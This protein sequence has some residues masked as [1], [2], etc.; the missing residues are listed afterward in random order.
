RQ[1]GHGL[2]VDRLSL[3]P[4][5]LVGGQTDEDG[6]DAFLEG[7]A[8][9]EGIRQRVAAEEHPA[10]LGVGAAVAAAFGGRGN[11][12]ARLG[13]GVEA[14]DV[15]EVSGISAVVGDGAGVGFFLVADGPAGAVV[16]VEFEASL[17]AFHG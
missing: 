17:G 3:T 5:T 10:E 15:P 2:H 6:L 8:L 4:D 13:G 9:V 16:V 11:V 1:W 14:V 12:F 7:G